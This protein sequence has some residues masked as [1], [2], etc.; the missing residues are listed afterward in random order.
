MHIIFLLVKTAYIAVLALSPSSNG[1]PNSNR[2]IRLTSPREQLRT[3]IFDSNHNSC[4]HT[5]WSI[6]PATMFALRSYFPVSSTM[7][8]STES[9]P[10][11]STM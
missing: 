3:S 2:I 9:L 1:S 6:A 8:C 4:R 11:A 5:I 10:S 7:F